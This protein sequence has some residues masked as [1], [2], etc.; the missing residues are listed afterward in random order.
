MQA[1]VNKSKPSTFC[2]GKPKHDIVTNASLLGLLRGTAEEATCEK[3]GYVSA[4]T[5]PQPTQTASNA[6]PVACN[7]RAHAANAWNRTWSATARTVM[8]Y[9]AVTTCRAAMHGALHASELPNGVCLTPRYC[10]LDSLSS[11]PRIPVFAVLMHHTCMRP[12]D[13][14][15]LNLAVC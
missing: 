15:L 12:L 10:T 5:S 3:Q 4:D 2:P 8:W 14:P 7:A 11:S 13:A 9:H 1:C 6:T